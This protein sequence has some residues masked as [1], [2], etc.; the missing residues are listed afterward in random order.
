MTNTE[1]TPSSEDVHLGSG[2]ETSKF[3]NKLRSNVKSDLIEITED[4]LENILLKHLR[5]MAIRKEWITPFSL[6]LTVLLA[7]LTATFAKKFGID[8]D[9]WHAFFLLFAFASFIWLVVS[10]VRLIGRW[11][12]ASIDNLIAI[13]KNAE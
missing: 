1:T 5:K 2:P 10:V 7:N 3:I 12:E 13:I 6:F 11:K 9:V 4:K 8:A